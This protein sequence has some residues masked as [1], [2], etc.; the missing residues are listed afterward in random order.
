M[1]TIRQTY[2]IKAPRK[3][4]WEVLVTPKHI[5]KW[6][7]GPAKMSTKEGAKFSLWG[8]DIF[9]K[10]TEVK[11]D[12]SLLQ[13]WYGGEW[14]EPSVVTISLTTESGGT[15]VSLLHTGFPEEEG[16]DLKEGWKDYYFGPLKEYVEGL[17]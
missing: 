11:E 5:A 17:K 15:K 4:V 6:G 2:H 12:K 1:K 8:G 14:L 13:D 7:A 16:A 3:L 9:G 10:N